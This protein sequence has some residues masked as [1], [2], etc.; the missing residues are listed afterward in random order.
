MNVNSN[1]GADNARPQ[2]GGIIIDTQM[3]S[4]ASRH[5]FSNRIQLVRQKH[6]LKSG[7][8]A[9]GTWPAF[10]WVV[11][12]LNNSSSWEEMHRRSTRDLNGASIAKARSYRSRNDK[13]F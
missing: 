12:G 9:I 1:M 5:V 13:S 10:S 11:E 2:M 3:A 8:N 7:P 4:A 6:T